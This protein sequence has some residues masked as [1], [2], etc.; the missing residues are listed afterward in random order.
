MLILLV[1][2]A[3]ILFFEHINIYFSSIVTNCDFFT[4]LPIF[5]YGDMVIDPKTS[6]IQ[7]IL[8]RKISGVMVGVDLHRFVSYH[9]KF[10]KIHIN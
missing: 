7:Q 2:V 1:F 5:S 6:P 10:V 4:N 8:T 3:N 9:Y